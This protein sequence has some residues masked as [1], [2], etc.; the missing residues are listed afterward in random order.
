MKLA[1]ML[2]LFSAQM[3]NVNKFTSLQQINEAVSIH[4][5]A[6]PKS[7]IFQMFDKCFSF[8][9]YSLLA[10]DPLMEPIINLAVISL[11]EATSNEAL[12][13][14]KRIVQMRRSTK[15]ALV[16]I[17][18]MCQNSIK[19]CSFSDLYY[20]ATLYE[21][22][23]QGSDYSND[24]MAKEITERICESTDAFSMNSLIEI[25]LYASLTKH[26]LP[27]L[28]K[29]FKKMILRSKEIDKSC[30]IKY[31]GLA[32]DE[33]INGNP[34]GPYNFFFATLMGYQPR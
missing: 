17:L 11:P 23:A 27:A 22:S 15:E 28:D 3:F 30:F 7:E 1:S 14:G 19:S 29:M 32:N 20:M 13:A 2:R 34:T 16:T 12:Q 4:K 5:D 24:K 31:S 8:K 9:H 25:S 26:N 6:I 10:E 18:S 21:L 33:R